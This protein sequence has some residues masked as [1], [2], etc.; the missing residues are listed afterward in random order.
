MSRALR[1]PW[2][3]TAFWY[4][5]DV[6]AGGETIFPRSGGGAHPRVNDV[7]VLQRERVG[8]LCTPRQGKMIVFYNL[9]PNGETLSTPSRTAPWMTL[10]VGSR[11]DRPHVSSRRVPS[12]GRREVGR[13][14]VS[15]FYY[16]TGYV[17]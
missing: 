14:Q 13:Q 10:C 11:R 15:P 2:Q 9:L 1:A 16:S 17:Y 12:A 8:L 3:A 5:T 6:E 4:M 7:E